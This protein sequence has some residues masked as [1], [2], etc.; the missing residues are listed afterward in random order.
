[1]KKQTDVIFRKHKD[2]EILAIFPASYATLQGHLTCYAHVGQHGACSQGYAAFTKAASPD[3]YRD[4]FAELIRI[5][6][7][8]RVC[9]KRTA[10]HRKLAD[11]SV[12]ACY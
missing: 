11:E 5:G 9:K 10:K 6:Y 3:E 8:L 1:M 12:R 7:D 2:G 4:L